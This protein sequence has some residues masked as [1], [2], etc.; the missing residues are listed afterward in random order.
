MDKRAKNEGE[1]N[2]TADRKYREAATR[3]ARSGNSEEQARAAERA[4]D[5]DEERE[6]L[7][8]AERAAKQKQKP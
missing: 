5:D 1:G 6:E 7:P 3:H 8:D 2:K 4:I